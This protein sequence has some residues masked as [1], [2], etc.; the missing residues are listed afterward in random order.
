MSQKIRI[1]CRKPG[2]RR[3]GI[4]HPAEAEYPADRFTAEELALLRAEPLLQ[5][6]LVG[7][8][9]PPSE[10]GKGKGKAAG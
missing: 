4:A 3:A 8:P 9:E 2:F 5:V 6:D 10:G 1:L 7:E